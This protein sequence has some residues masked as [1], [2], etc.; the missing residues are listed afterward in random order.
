[1][2]LDD[3]TT[4]MTGTVCN[5]EEID[6]AIFGIGVQFVKL[7]LLVYF[8]EY[9]EAAKIF[10]NQGDA[11]DKAFPG[12]LDGMHEAFLRGIAMYAMARKTKKRKYKRNANNARKKIEASIKR[13]N[14]NVKLYYW[15]LCAEQASLCNDHKV[16][17]SKY[18]EAITGAA[19]SGNL[20][21]AAL[22]NERYADYFENILMDTEEYEY[23]M[24]ES[25]R[26]YQ[27]WGAYA[28]VNQLTELRHKTAPVKEN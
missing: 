16:A 24:D 5:S 14:P 28:K 7:S 13:G 18:N 10:M 9:E 17:K 26:F 27:R 11:H 15:L 19:R 3:E 2:G 4:E 6:M 25:I 12:L 8:R 22:A 20:Y 23:R 21:M 1:M